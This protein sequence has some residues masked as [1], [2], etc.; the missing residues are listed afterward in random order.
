MPHRVRT[1]ITHL[2]YGSLRKLNILPKKPLFTG[3]KKGGHLPSTVK[4]IGYAVFG[5][6]L[7]H[8][9]QKV[10]AIVHGL[11]YIHKQIGAYDLYVYCAQ[12]YFKQPSAI[13]KT[14]F[15]KDKDFYREISDFMITEF[16]T[17]TSFELCPEWTVG[18]ISGHPDI[19][20]DNT[21]YDVKTTCQFGSMRVQTIFQLLAYYCLAQQLDKKITH[22]GIILPAQKAVL[23]ADLSGWKWQ[24]FWKALSACI[25]IKK[26]LRAPPEYTLLFH[27]TILPHV[28]SHVPKESTVAR[29]LKG[30][31]SSQ[32]WQIFFGGRCNVN[33][34]VT[35]SDI[36]NTLSLTTN[37]G[38]RFYVHSPYT[39]NVSRKYD[40]DWVVKSL[41]RHLTT[42]V[43]MGCKGVVVHC[44][45]KKKGI[46]YEVAY[47]NMVYTVIQAAEMATPECPLLIETS[48]G[49]TG[50]LLSKPEELIAFYHSLP[51]DT[52]INT[53]ICVDTCHVFAAGYLPQEFV[54]ELDDAKVPI[55]L[56]HFNDSK[57]NKGCCKDRHENLGAGY[58][59]LQN[60]ISVGTYALQNG[61]DMIFE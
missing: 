6:F 58:I 23:S 53:K 13:E 57:G 36:A 40:D 14:V 35:D 16:S 48:A 19:V 10:L 52:K 20:I 32:P 46:E 12:H 27:N 24:Q 39:I 2:E 60:L 33:F 44:G 8:F 34:K 22:V 37:K 43:S 28:G 50:E 30:L 45:V 11:E 25:E 55:G 1:L 59:G 51:E 9:I 3:I 49:E 31:S 29:T 5:M 38:Y 47:K 61:I 21:V 15:H 7:D 4:K 56:F 17:A 26:K 41:G 42:G 54:K 18:N